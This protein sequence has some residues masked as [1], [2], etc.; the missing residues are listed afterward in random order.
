MFSKVEAKQLKHEF[1]EGFDRYTKF[2]SNKIKE[3]IQWIFYKTGIKGLELKFD[4]SK[5]NIQVIIEANAKNENRRFDIYLE[6]NKYKAIIEDGFIHGLIWED[7]YMKGEGVEVSRALVEEK[8]F[9]FHNRDHWPDIYRFMAEN[10]YRLQTNLLD[11]LPIL[12]EQL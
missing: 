5:K 1:W 2:Y 4:V 11:I 3:P 7:D 12:K 10:M 8:S 9:N 6:L